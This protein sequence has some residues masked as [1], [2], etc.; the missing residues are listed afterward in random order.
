MFLRNYWYVAASDSEIGRKPLPRMILGEPVVFFRTEDRDTVEYACW[1][2]GQYERNRVYDDGHRESLDYRGL[3]DGWDPLHPVDEHEAIGGGARIFFSAAAGLL[4]PERLAIGSAQPR[5]AYADD[6]R[7]V[8][9]AVSREG[10]DVAQIQSLQAAA[11]RAED[12]ERDYRKSG[13]DLVDALAPADLMHMGR[14]HAFAQVQRAGA[15]RQ[16]I[17][18]VDHDFA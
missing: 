4:N 18:G 6:G 14:W 5:R 12:L 11:W 15:L 10:G 17:I 2:A 8:P 9:G 1:C 13:N 3:I 16:D 7:F